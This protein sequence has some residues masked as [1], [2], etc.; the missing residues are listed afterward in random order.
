MIRT[1]I[2]SVLML[3]SPSLWGSEEAATVTRVELRSTVR[4]GIDQTELTLGDLARIDGPQANEL[5]TLTIKA[6]KAISPGV[7]SELAIEDIKEQ[8]KQA[9]S[10]NYG[11]IVLTGPDIRITRRVDRAAVIEQGDGTITPANPTQGTVRQQIE[12]WLIARLDTTPER[13]RIRFD[14]R[15]NEVL[16]TPSAGRVVELREIGRS[17]RVVVG[18]VIIEHERVVIDRS[19]QVEVLI[20]QPARVATQQI[21]RREQIND[22][23]TRIER[24]WLPVTTTTASPEDAL[25]L[26]SNTTIDPGKLILSSMLEEPLLVKRGE[27]VNARSIA[28]SVSVSLQV[29]AKDSGKLGDI[30]ELESR[31]RQQQFSARVA[32]RG[33]VVIIHQS[34]TPTPGSSS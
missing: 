30:I 27:I 24:R 12:R 16:N 29:R 13:S 5:Q 10:I 20:D 19:V 28:G 11:A 23:N 15:D 25:G 31:D 2:I 6:K 32:G 1:F 3:L 18:V 4:M 7:W 8:I 9:S 21:Q 17:Q 33:R 26:I 22:E 34:S 14:E